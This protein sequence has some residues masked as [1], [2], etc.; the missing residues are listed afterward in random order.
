[1]LPEVADLLVQPGGPFVSDKLVV[2]AV[3]G[4]HARQEALHL[5]RHVVLYEPELHPRPAHAPTHFLS[6]QLLQHL[7]I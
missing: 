3:V 5:R 2:K 6:P 1:M 4:G 7:L